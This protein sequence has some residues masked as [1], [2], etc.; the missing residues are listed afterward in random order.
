MTEFFEKKK[1]LLCSDFFDRSTKV[2]A[3]DLI[4]KTLV[5]EVNGVRVSGKVVETEAY[6]GVRDLACHASRGKTPRNEVMFGPA[7]YWYVYLI[8]GF[9]HCLNIVTEGVGSGSAVLIR[10]VEPLDGIVFMQKNRQREVLGDLSSG[11][12]KL[13]QAF[14]VTRQLNGASAC[15]LAS[16][17]FFEEA[18]HVPKKSILSTKRIGV[19][20]AGAWKDKP[21]RFCMKDS[22]FVSKSKLVLR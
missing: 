8:Y 3:R 2:V 16:E 19:E 5:R 20:Y 13:C 17:C 9:Y 7:G 6:V 14:G 1:L 4:G 22:P 10:A 21:L 18:E 12:G 15:A 11:P